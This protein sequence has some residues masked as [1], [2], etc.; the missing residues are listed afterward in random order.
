MDKEN[1]A[2]NTQTNGSEKIIANIKNIVLLE[3]SKV[4][5]EI[6]RDNGIHK[7]TISNTEQ[8]V[9]DDNHSDLDSSTEDENENSLTNTRSETFYKDAQQYWMKV[10]ATIDGMLGGLSNVSF[11][12]I[13]GSQDFLKDIFKMKP[14]P[15]NN[16]ALDCGAGEFK[17]CQFVEFYRELQTNFFFYN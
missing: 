7:L 11:T 12:D 5:E 6:I 15:N 3:K 16:F 4:S 14:S 13:R 9:N 1:E 17:H 10:P 2:F 8:D